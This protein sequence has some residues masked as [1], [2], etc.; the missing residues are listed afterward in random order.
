MFGW[1][2]SLF[3]NPFGALVQAFDA[4]AA[5]FSNFMA[6]RHMAMQDTHPDLELVLNSIDDPDGAKAKEEVYRIRMEGGRAMTEAE[7][8]R[9]LWVALAREALGLIIGLFLVKLPYMLL[10]HGLIIGGAMLAWVV[11]SNFQLIGT[12]LLAVVAFGVPFA[13]LLWRPI[14]LIVA[15]MIEE[16]PLF[17]SFFRLGVGGPSGRFAGLREFAACDMSDYFNPNM[18]TPPQGE[19][20]DIYLGRTPF[21][22]DV[23]LLDMTE[24][25]LDAYRQRLREAIIEVQSF[26]EIEEGTEPQRRRDHGLE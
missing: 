19:T 1:R 10:K 21:F 5:R 3:A 4:R 17:V 16:H 12:M 24:E 11:L 14:K 6:D 2:Y 9:F 26:E 18:D 8:D 25:E 7:L 20:S 15:H 13:I 23:R 22:E